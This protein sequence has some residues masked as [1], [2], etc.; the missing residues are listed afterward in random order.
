MNRTI[1][2]ATSKPFHYPSRHG[3]RAHVLAFVSAYNYAKHLK[4]RKRCRADL[5]DFRLKA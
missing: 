1:K 4:A 2:D 3:S 5:V